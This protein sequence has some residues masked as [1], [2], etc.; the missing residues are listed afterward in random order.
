MKN[1]Y[2]TFEKAS[3]IKTI[4]IYQIIKIVEKQTISLK[5]ILTFLKEIE[6]L[7]LNYQ[8]VLFSFIKGTI[9]NFID[10]NNMDIS[11]VNK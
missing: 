11:N 9:I 10:V 6:A 5:D 8:N 2:C 3:D 1:I 7:H 4:K